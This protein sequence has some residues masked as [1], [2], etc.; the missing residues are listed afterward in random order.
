MHRLAMNELSGPVSDRCPVVNNSSACS[1][2]VPVCQHRPVRYPLG[3][4]T[5]AITQRMPAAAVKVS[6]VRTLLKK[7]MNHD[8]EFSL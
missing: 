1:R 3:I 7:T 4:S 5:S 2:V 8:A 6:Y